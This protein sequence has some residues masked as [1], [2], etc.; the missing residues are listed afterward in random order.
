MLLGCI[1]STTLAEPLHIWTSRGLAKAVMTDDT[2][3]VLKVF[4]LQDVRHVRLQGTMDDLSL[5]IAA[6]VAL[7]TALALARAAISGDPILWDSLCVPR[8]SAF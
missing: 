5:F 8:P 4:L 2:L 7:L 6:N 3:A 1:C